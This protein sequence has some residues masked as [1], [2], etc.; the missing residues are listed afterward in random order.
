MVNKIDLTAKAG[1]VDSEQQDDRVRRFEQLS[2]QME[3]TALAVTRVESASHDSDGFEQPN[4]GN[5]SLHGKR[6][7][8]ASGRVRH[9]S[10][11]RPTFRKGITT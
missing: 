2:K 9:I 3:A 5:S 8:R 7:L 10:M 6:I 4:P 11:N 1:Q